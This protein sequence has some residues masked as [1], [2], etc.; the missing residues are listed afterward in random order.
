MNIRL[1]MLLAVFCCTSG[2]AF[3]EIYRTVDAEGNVVYTDTPMPD[4]KPVDLPPAS[5][6]SPP[7]YA[8]AVP[9]RGSA[10]EAEA[11]EYYSDVQI[12]Q[13]GDEETIRAN[14]GNVDVGVQ[15]APELLV[16][17]GH[18]LQFYLDGQPVGAPSTELSTTLSNID[19]GEH[20]IAAAI[21]DSGGATLERTDPR[22]FYVQ[23]YSIL[24]APESGT[25][26]SPVPPTPPVA[27]TPR[28]PTP[29]TPR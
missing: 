25:P 4:S 2:A 6:Y 16:E 10:Q 11:L 28:L 8:T 20:T 24:T 12:V 15:V 17:A 27:P 9:E 1:T 14:V 3:A 5:T 13:P 21:I 23:R 19:R 18:R 26:T 22:R 7:R 29:P